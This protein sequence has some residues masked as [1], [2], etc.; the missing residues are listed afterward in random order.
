MDGGQLR[1]RPP[2]SNSALA[3]SIGRRSDWS[4]SG[5]SI[6][7]RKIGPCIRTRKSRARHAVHTRRQSPIDRNRSER[8]T[9]AE[10]EGR[11]PFFRTR[12]GRLGCFSEGEGHLR[13]EELF[14]RVLRSVPA[15]TSTCFPDSRVHPGRRLPTNTTGRRFP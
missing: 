8:L 3:R 4:C 2:E 15:R 11:T 12:A 6:P 10:L 1:R 7:W 13:R 5:L 9:L 14:P